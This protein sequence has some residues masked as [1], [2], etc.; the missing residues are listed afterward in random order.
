M[1]TEDHS[2]PVPGVPAAYWLAG[3]PLP[4]CAPCRVVGAGVLPAVLKETGAE[5]NFEEISWNPSDDVFERPY[6][7]G[8]MMD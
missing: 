5:K 6:C 4:K 8:R 7:H 3:Y 1:A 2:A